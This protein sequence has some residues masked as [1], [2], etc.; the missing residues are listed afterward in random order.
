MTRFYTDK[1]GRVRPITGRTRMLPLV[2]YAHA[3]SFRVRLV[4]DKIGDGYVGMNS[5][6]AKALGI[7]FPYSRDTILVWKGLT[8]KEQRETFLHEIDEFRLMEKG[9]NYGIAHG[10]AN[11]TEK[12]TAIRGLRSEA[13]SNSFIF[14]L[15]T[16]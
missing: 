4:P 2:K 12:L 16:L 10:I 7:H 11:G 13:L 15:K 14:P 9:L 1:E 8:R 3:H 6:A 5:E